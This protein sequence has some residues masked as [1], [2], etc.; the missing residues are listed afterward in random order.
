MSE[1]A[2]IGAG[3]SGLAAAYRLQASGFKVTIFESAQ[4]AGG[5]AVGR[6]WNAWDWPLELFYHHWFTND[7]RIKY[8]AKELDLS[9]LIRTYS[10]Q[11]SFYHQGRIRPF[12]K[13]HHVLTFPGLTLMGR[14]RLGLSLAKFKLT[15]SWQRYEQTTAE[16]WLIQNMGQNVY[17][18][19]WKPMLIGKWGDYY[20]KINMAW[21]WARIYKR[22]QSLMY[23]DG[24]YQEFT[25]KIKENLEKRGVRFNLGQ[26]IKLVEQL[27]DHKIGVHTPSGPAQYDMVLTTV[28][29]KILLA[30]VKDLPKDYRNKV[31]ALENMGAIC[32]SFSLKRSIV[33]RSYWVNIPTNSSDPLKSEVPFLVFVEHTNMI[34]AKHYNNQHIVYCANYIKPGHDLFNYSKEDVFK[35]YFRGLKKLNP[36]I[37]EDDII[38]YHLVKAEYASPVFLP[39]HSKVVPSFDTPFK[40]LYWASMSHVCPWDRGTNYAVDMGLKV[41]EHIIQTSKER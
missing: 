33:D 4:V 34:P 14:L 1:V 11:T 31:N 18:K 21:F 20:N 3:Y 36:D 16:M 35:I 12:D 38:D 26:E 6:Q 19:L 25:D 37:R 23:P 32:M 15:T 17:D 24:G 7:D 5:L 9:H 22:T 28:S 2:I 29:P 13:P 41:A 30:T 8:L 39:G 10:P 40:N 27:E